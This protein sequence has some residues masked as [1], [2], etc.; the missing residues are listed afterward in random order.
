MSDQWIEKQV[1][2]NNIISP[3]EK[4]QIRE[5]KISY[6]LSSYGYD[7]RVSDEFKVFTNVNNTIVDPK[8]FSLEGFVERGE[9]VADTVVDF[10]S[11]LFDD[12]DVAGEAVEQDADFLSGHMADANGGEAKGT[13]YGKSDGDRN[14]PAGENL[15]NGLNGW[16][17]LVKFHFSVPPWCRV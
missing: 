14:Q 2:E 6:G 12:G 7:A 9:A 5:G 8:N 10:G 16:V 17:L 1:Q 4:T 15:F 11:R 3:F 13:N